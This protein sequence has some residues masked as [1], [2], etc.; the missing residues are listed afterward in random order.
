MLCILYTVTI[1]NIEVSLHINYSSSFKLLQALGSYDV[2]EK[3]MSLNVVISGVEFW[4]WVHK[5][6]LPVA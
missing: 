1:V 2:S 3:G 4:L 6:C 5:L